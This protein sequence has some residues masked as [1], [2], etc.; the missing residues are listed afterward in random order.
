V[1][2]PAELQALPPDRQVVRDPAKP[3]RLTI[4]PR[5]TLKTIGAIETASSST[6]PGQGAGS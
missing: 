5:T 1:S 3:G 4:S 2:L 6:D